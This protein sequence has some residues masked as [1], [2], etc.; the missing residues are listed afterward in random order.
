MQGADR[1]AITALGRLEPAGG[2]AAVG[3]FSE[4]RLAELSVAE[5]D[6][7]EAGQ[8]LFHLDSHVERE[9][10]RDLATAQLVAARER[11]D[12]EVKLAEQAIRDAA[13]ELRRVRELEPVEIEAEVARVELLAGRLATVR[14]S[15]ERKTGLGESISRES[16]DQQQAEVEEAERSLAA[17]RADL[18][19]R[20]VGHEIARVKAEA[21]LER[22]RM[23]L[24]RTHVLYSTRIA[25]REL[26]RAETRLEATIIRAPQ[27]GQV[28]KII[29]DP[30]ERIGSRPVLQLGN[31]RKMH[32]VAEVY[33]TDVRFVQPG[34]RASIKNPSFHGTVAGEVTS[35]G[36]LVFKNDILD[37]DPIADE[38]TRVVEVRIRL[39]D[40]ES[41]SRLTNLEVDVEILLEANTTPGE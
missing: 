18:R 30:G 11:L 22:S 14:R 7:V 10:D 9:A 4:A 34:Q 13:T 36:L 29:R 37:I 12:S 27:A 25:E 39:D 1:R 3:A 33:E 38:D 5:G 16:L 23:L 31:T 40:S 24:R 17:A 15:L 28:L 35:I 32:V 19:A 26:N 41:V 6:W 21:D 2:V 8:A 20:Q